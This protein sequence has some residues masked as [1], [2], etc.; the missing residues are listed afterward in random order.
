[1]ALQ[2]FLDIAQ[3][4]LNSIMIRDISNRTDYISY[5]GGAGVA[6]I[7][8]TYI[9]LQHS[10]EASPRYLIKNYNSYLPVN[11]VTVTNPEF[12]VMAAD[13][14][15]SGGTIKSPQV[16]TQID[17]FLDGIYTYEYGV[18]IDPGTTSLVSGKVYMVMTGGTINLPVGSIVVADNSIIT[19][20]ATLT[21]SGA[22]KFIEKNL[23]GT[24]IVMIC[25]NLLKDYASA[26]IKLNKTSNQTQYNQIKDLINDFRISF[27]R[28]KALVIVDDYTQAVVSFADCRTILNQILTLS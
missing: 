25:G 14:A 17:T 20:S 16:L 15:V 9:K 19:P 12:K 5:F 21:A 23:I 27:D 2:L 13:V 3:P 4:S 7:V 8:G 22:V 24:G 1:M 6:D 28:T 18:N 10:S 11:D 26:L